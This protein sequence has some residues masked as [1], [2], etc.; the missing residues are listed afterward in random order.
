M[1]R[2]AQPKPMT[3]PERLVRRAGS[4][5]RPAET[6]HLLDRLLGDDARR[7]RDRAARRACSRPCATPSLGGG[8]RLRPFLVVETA[9]LFGV[10]ARRTR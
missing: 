4:T 3:A 5:P 10:A 1:S 6:E 8:K 2:Y 9:A 7:R